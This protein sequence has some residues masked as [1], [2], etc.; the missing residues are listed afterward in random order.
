MIKVVKAVM[1]M[2]MH[3]TL[4]MQQHLQ[5]G[6]AQVSHSLVK[7]V[8]RQKYDGLCVQ[9]HHLQAAGRQVSQAGKVTY[10]LA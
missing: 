1:V 5:A 10:M 9:Q 8:E 7:V 3:D 4:C 6:K 2:Q